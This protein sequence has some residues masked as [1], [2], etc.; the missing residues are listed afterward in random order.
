MTLNKGAV[1]INPGSTKVY[2]TGEWRTYKPTIDLVKCIKCGKCW[3]ICPDASIN[4][5]E[6]DGKFE[7]NHTYCKGCLLCEKVCP[8]KAISHVV[9]D[10]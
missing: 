1:I 6:T 2:K 10:K 3:M 9:E 5:R 4:K 7:I 8:V